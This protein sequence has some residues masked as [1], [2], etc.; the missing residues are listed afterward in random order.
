MEFFGQ[1]RLN[2]GKSILRKRASRL[3]R[4]ILYN[5]FTGIRK[6]GLVW[7]A[8]KTDDFQ[9]ISRFHQRMSERGIDT[10]VFAFYAGKELPDKLTAIRFL[11]CMRKKDLNLYYIPVSGEAVKFIQ[12]K[13]DVLIDL[14]FEETFPLKYIAVLSAAGFKVG[15]LNSD[16]EARFYDLMME[17]K[18]PFTIE[19]YLNEVVNY[20]EMINSGSKAINNQ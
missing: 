18:R 13:Y 14:N 20:L 16:P 17:L 2:I 3:S 8:G 7:D 9:H 19:Y 12:T 4:K 5:G 11:T 6:I 15:I 10:S 1:V